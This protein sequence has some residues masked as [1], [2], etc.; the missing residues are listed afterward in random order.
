MDALG[1]GYKRG[2]ECIRNC[3][4]ENMTF[5][6]FRALGRV[7]AK[8]QYK[9]EDKQQAFHLGWWQ[10]G[11][12]FLVLFKQD[13]AD[14]YGA[15]KRVDE[16]RRQLG[17]ACRELEAL[18]TWRPEDTALHS[19][20]QDASQALDRVQNNLDMASDHLKKKV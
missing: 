5:E 16:V 7:D 18:L 20:L 3:R 10:S 11:E 17:V 19:L 14:A 6:E 4:I 15:S 12:R 1:N 8:R 13:D 2:C 9:R